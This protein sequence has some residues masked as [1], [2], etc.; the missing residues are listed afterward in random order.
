MSDFW[1]YLKLGFYHVLDWNAYDHILFLIVLTVAYTFSNWKKVLL[2]VTLFTLGHT[3][4]L[5]LSVYGVV[6]VNASLVEFLIPITIFFA[7]LFNVFTASNS[8]KYEKVGVLYATTVFFGII[9]G[10][11]FSNYFNVISSNVSSKT[12]PLIEFA[13]GVELAQIV[14]VFIVLLL[15]FI[16]QTVFRFSKRDWILV[17]SSI[18]IGMVI[19]MIISNKIW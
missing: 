14:V 7:A 8:N 19:P 16:I 12:L 11:G 4:S 10:L 13:L 5:F 18:V 3:M 2:L 17:I 1:L 9:H 15:S 6:R